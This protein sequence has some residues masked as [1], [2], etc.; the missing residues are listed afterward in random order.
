MSAVCVTPREDDVILLSV[1]LVSDL[2]VWLEKV[3]VVPVNDVT[4]CNIWSLS[5]SFKE[6]LSSSLVTSA[7]NHMLMTDD[8]MMTYNACSR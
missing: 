4:I 3:E 7:V 2:P 5:A 6:F 1:N 8:I